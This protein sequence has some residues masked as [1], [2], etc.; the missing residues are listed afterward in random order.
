MART[1][2]VSPDHFILK[3]LTY[4]VPAALL[5]ILTSL[6]SPLGVLR[7]A[8]AMLALFGGLLLLTLVAAP[9]SRGPHAGWHWAPS[10]S[11]RASS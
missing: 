7:L 2:H 1:L 3:H 11:S 8:M 5:L 6:L 9:T 4:L 10:S